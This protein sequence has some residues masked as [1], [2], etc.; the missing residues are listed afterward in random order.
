MN[1]PYAMAWLGAGGG[2]RSAMRFKSH[3]PMLF[4]YGKRKPFM[5]HSGRWLERLNTTPGSE[6]VAVSSGHW[7]TVDRPAEL[8]ALLIDWLEQEQ[9]EP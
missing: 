4:L 9:S 1:F 6:A 5:F 2:L 7:L 3:C 8:N